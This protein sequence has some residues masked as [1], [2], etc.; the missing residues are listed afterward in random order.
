MCTK[1]STIQSLKTLLSDVTN[2]LLI[3]TTDKEN[4]CFNTKNKPLMCVKQS[5]YNMCMFPCTLL[6]AA[7]QM[8]LI[9]IIF[10]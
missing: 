8:Y 10:I 1:A 5:L 6:L 3:E 7:M 9:M 4:E 2:Y